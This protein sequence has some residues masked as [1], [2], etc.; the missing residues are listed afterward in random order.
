MNEKKPGRSS[1]PTFRVGAAAGESEPTEIAPGVRPFLT[2]EQRR[3]QRRPEPVQEIVDRLM[4]GV[5]GGR[6][7]PAALLGAQWQEVVGADFAAKTGP[8]SCE[9]G[10]LV[11]LV[12]DG[13]TASKMRFM[14]SQILQNAT[15]IVGDGVVSAISFRVSPTMDQ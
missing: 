9:S 13:A 2:E 14:T 4:T 1:P 7:A 8:G 15:K 10:R 5:S 3:S 6:A 12:A 11:V